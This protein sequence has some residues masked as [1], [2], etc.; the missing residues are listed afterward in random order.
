MDPIELTND[1]RETLNSDLLNVKKS[2]ENVLIVYRYCMEWY[3][4]AMQ[5]EIDKIERVVLYL[6]RNELNDIH[7]LEK[8][9]AIK[10]VNLEVKIHSSALSHKINHFRSFFIQFQFV[11]NSKTMDHEFV[12][13]FRRK[14]DVDIDAQYE[15]F[16]RANDKKRYDF[17]VKPNMLFFN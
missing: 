13:Y 6:T 15:S 11:A 3:S 17:E 8:Q 2:I 1:D 7:Q 9:A 14:I 12:S 5:N 4:N 16:Q 10:M